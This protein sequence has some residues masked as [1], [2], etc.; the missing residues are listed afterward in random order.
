MTAYRIPGKGRVD[1][2][3]AVRFHFNGETYTGYQGDTLASAL[4]ANGIHL[5]GRSFK[6]HRPRGIL[7]AGS[8]EPNALVGT[9]RG[10]GRFEP[11]TRATMVEIFDGL[12][13]PSPNPRRWL[14]QDVGP[15]TDALHMMSSAGLDSNTFSWQSSI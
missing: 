4:L 10:N 3:R 6:Y 8:E 1:H 11:N 14:E 15:V 2:R 9:D 12:Q 5:V 13:A 7:S